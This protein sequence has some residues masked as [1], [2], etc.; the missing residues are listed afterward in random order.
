MGR[1]GL[2][3]ELESWIPSLEVYRVGFVEQA[4]VL[5]PSGESG[6]QKLIGIG[7]FFVSRGQTVVFL[8]RVYLL[9]FIWADGF[10][11]VLSQL[12]TRY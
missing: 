6:D 1:A 9:G 4:R 11:T 2:E 10:S 12:Q 5:H 8:A 3:L 7:T